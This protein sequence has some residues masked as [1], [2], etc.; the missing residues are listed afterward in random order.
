MAELLTPIKIE[1]MALSSIK[2]TY[3]RLRSA[4]NK[5]LARLEKAGIGNYG[6]ARFAKIKDMSTQQ[7]YS[8]LADVSRFMND[9]RTTVR[10][11]R[12]YMSN[13]IDMFNEQGYS[14]I[15]ESNLYDFLDYMDDLRDQYSDKMFD[16]GDAVDIYNEAQRLGVS[17]DILK[18]HFDYFQDNIDAM[19]EIKPI[20]KKNN[21]SVTFSD[22]KRKIE[23]YNEK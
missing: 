10:G 19:E 4:A 6:S 8:N 12:R 21:K 18:K 17:S 23:R 2:E 7:L 5:R 16:S 13:M 11:Q 14:W 1:H 3:S 15:D 22:I 20:K 9:A